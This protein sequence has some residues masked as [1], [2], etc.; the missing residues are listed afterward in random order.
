M[1]EHPDEDQAILQGIWAEVESDW[2]N[3]AKH[4]LFV[5]TAR[6]RL[7]LGVAA[8]CYKTAAEDE[9]RAEQATKRLAQIAL[10]AEV[11]LTSTRSKRRSAFWRSN[12]GRL[13]LLILGT[14]LVMGLF[15]LTWIHR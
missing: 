7:A 12:L 8:E 4:R 13:L 9:A 2:D 14:V 6:D 15:W 5:D 3:E 1:S 10:L 11:T